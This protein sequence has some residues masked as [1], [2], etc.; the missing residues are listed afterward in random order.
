M[1]LSCILPF[2]LNII[3]EL[4]PTKRNYRKSV[5]YHS[6]TSFKALPEPQG[7]NSWTYLDILSPPLERDT[8]QDRRT[9]LEVPISLL[10]TESQRWMAPRWPAPCPHLDVLKL[11]IICL[12]THRRKTIPRWKINLYLGNVGN[13]AWTWAKLAAF[14]LSAA[15]IVRREN[16]W[17][18]KPIRSYKK[19]LSSLIHYEINESKTS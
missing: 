8:S 7:N 12:R 3:V 4:I 10:F 6:F 5:P 15:F 14:L 13:S 11:W 17:C 18:L 19:F 9:S 1:K 16:S 2:M